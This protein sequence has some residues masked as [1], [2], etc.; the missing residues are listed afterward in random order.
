MPPIN[1]LMKPASG[2]CNLNCKYCFY[3]SLQEEQNFSNNSM[4]NLDVLENIVKKA[5]EFADS[6]VS[7]GFQGGEPTLRGFDFF[8]KF[9]ELTNKYNSNKIKV[10]KYIQTNGLSVDEKWSEYFVKNNFLVG[11]SLDGPLK[12]H[13]VYRKKKNNEG[14]YHDVMKAVK[15]F[16][17]FKVEYN[18]LY[19]VTS[20]TVKETKKIYTWFKNNNFNY[21]QFIPCLDPMTV[22][23][24]S[25]QYSLTP[26]LYTKFLNDIFECWYNDFVNGKYISIRFIDNIVK[27]VAGQNAESCDMKGHCSIQNV[28]EANGDIYPCDFFVT[29]DWL[30][31]NIKD[32]DFSAIF[33]SDKSRKFIEKSFEKPD[34]CNKCRWNVICRNGCKRYRENGLNY[35]CDSFQGFL[36]SKI[37]KI[38][39]VLKLL[40]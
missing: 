12:V 17:K 1:I 11:L 26:N 14:S 29:K 10:N 22:K 27:I 32:T 35:Y 30:L 39:E 25:F 40:K 19:V 2:H 37:D 33:K 5:F 34:K 3:H 21:L 6:S 4:M 38:F 28:I 31:G 8:Q 20:N 18:I 9:I 24:G 7:F 23:R 15:I 13:N 16:N 36:N